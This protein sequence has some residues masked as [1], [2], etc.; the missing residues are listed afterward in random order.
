[1]V[2]G[3]FYMIYEIYDMISMIQRGILVYILYDDIIWWWDVMRTRW[4]LRS[5]TSFYGRT[6]DE[7]RIWRDY[8]SLHRGCLGDFGSGKVIRMSSWYITYGQHTRVNT[9]VGT[10]YD[11]FWFSWYKIY[12]YYVLKSICIIKRILVVSDFILARRCSEKVFDRP[13]V[14][15]KR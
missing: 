9:S 2:C 15:K 1:M 3:W 14:L 12:M 7:D 4:W 11:I 13:W 6:C 5:T 10:V 8:D